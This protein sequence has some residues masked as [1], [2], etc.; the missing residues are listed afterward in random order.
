MVQALNAVASGTSSPWR[1]SL[2]W[3]VDGWRIFRLAPFSLLGLS[4]LPIA[5]EGAWQLVP[6]LGIFASKLLTPLAS[7]WALAMLDGKARRNKFAARAS[8]RLV[9]ERL[10]DLLAVAVLIVGVFAFQLVI[11]A[12]IGGTGQASALAFGQFAEISLSPPQLAFVFAS[13]VLPATVLMFVL[14]RVLFDGLRA[15]PAAQESARRVLMYWR[16]AAVLAAISATSVAALLWLP[17]LLLMLLP[18]GLC[19]GYASYRDVFDTD[20]G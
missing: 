2:R 19:V 4:L 16:P 13:G 9:L 3:L 20:A 18:F 12:A 5:F 11:A 15:I 8:G 10:P 14:P 17:V 7:A 6:V 1:H